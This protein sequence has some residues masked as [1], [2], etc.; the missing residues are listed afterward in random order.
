MLIFPK[1]TLIPENSQGVL[2]RGL[3]LVD[4]TC[5]ISL[6]FNHSALITLPSYKY[7][8]LTTTE[9]A[10]QKPTWHE[11]RQREHD[12]LQWLSVIVHKSNA[13]RMASLFLLFA[14]Y[15][16]QESSQGL[17]IPWRLSQSCL[18]RILTT[19]QASVWSVLNT[20]KKHGWLMN[21]KQGWCICDPLAL[22]TLRG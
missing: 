15:Y 9:I 21:Y 18:A 4:R 2:K 16:A 5:C 20:W 14:D 8:C 11:L 22:S 6:I 13:S 1:G 7:E 10:Y 12:M 19:S 17:Y 3:I